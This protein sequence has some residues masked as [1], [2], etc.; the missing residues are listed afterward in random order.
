MKKLLFSLVFILIPIVNANAREV[1]AWVDEKGAH[2]FFQEEGIS[3]NFPNME[4]VEEFF[5]ESGGDEFDIVSRE[6]LRTVVNEGAK[7]KTY[8]EASSYTFTPAKIEKK[9]DAEVIK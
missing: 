4:M 1:K 5:K 7:I 2:V 6:S 8:E 3:I 9:L